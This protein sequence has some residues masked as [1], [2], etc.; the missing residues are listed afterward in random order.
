MNLYNVIKH[1]LVTEKARTLEALQHSNSNACTRK[2]SA[3]KYVFIVD[4]K[5]NKQQIAEAIEKIYAEKNIKVVDVNTVNIKPKKRRLRGR[6][7][8]TD[9]FKKAIVTLE[10]GDNIDEA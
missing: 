10:P 5:A 6:Q 3:P 1:R 8:K 7:G 2:C 4:R 9:A